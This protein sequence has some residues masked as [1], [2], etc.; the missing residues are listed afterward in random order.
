MDVFVGIDP[1]LNSTG[2]CILKYDNEEK[3]SEYFA[4]IK[5]DKLSK[6]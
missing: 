6:K 5:P 1:S 4:I 2:L 3:I